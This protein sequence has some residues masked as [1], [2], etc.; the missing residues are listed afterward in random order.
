MSMELLDDQMRW[1]I[2][3]GYFTWTCYRCKTWTNTHIAAYY[4]LVDHHG[5]DP[6][7]AFDQGEAGEPRDRRR[8]ARP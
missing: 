1:L 6:Q 5:L 2:R 8:P 7:S 4:H 3:H